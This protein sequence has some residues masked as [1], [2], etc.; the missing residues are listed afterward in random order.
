MTSDPG[1]VR[2]EVAGFEGQRIDVGEE[3]AL[4]VGA[5]DCQD[6]AIGL[7]GAVVGSSADGKQ[8]IE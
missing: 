3:D 8:H 6:A 7:G 4:P 1:S 5:T 2:S